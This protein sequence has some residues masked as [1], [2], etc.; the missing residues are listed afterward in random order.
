MSPL[1]NYDAAYGGKKGAG[2]KA[3][4]AMVAQYGEKRG[5]RMFYA[6]ANM[7]KKAYGKAARKMREVALAQPSPAPEITEAAA[8]LEMLYVNGFSAVQDG[9]LSFEAV[10]SAV[11]SAVSEYAKGEDG[12]MARMPCTVVA[13]FL[14]T[15]V[16]EHEGKLYQIDYK[17]NGTEATLD[18]EAAEVAAD[19]VP[20]G[21]ALGESRQAPLIEARPAGTIRHDQLNRALNVIEGTVLITSQSVNGSGK[22][23]RR[24]SDNALRQIAER[25]EGLPAY[26]NHVA[27]EHA[28][29]P[30]DVRDLIGSHRNI[31]YYPNEG[32]IVS[33]LHIAEHQAPLVFGLATTLG[34]HIGNSLV[35]RGL[36]QMEGD[37]EVVKEIADVRSVDLVS[38]PATTKGLFEARADDADPLG[39]L[40]T[41]LRESLTHVPKEDPMDLAAILTFLKDK[42]EQQALVAESFGFVAKPAAGKLQEQ[43]VTLTTERDTFKAK[44]DE[45]EAAQVKTTADLKEATIKLD[46]YKAKDAL[47]EKR[48]KI[49][50]AI[51]AH[52]LGKQFGKIKEVVSDGFKTML[53]GLDEAQWKSVLDDRFASLKAVPSSGGTP[54]SERKSD[55]LLT[56]HKDGDALP[57]GLEA[58]LAAAL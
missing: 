28:F 47:A 7:K 25:A 24:Y 45:V 39:T 3:H 22:G 27:A 50:T 34:G 40:I 56:E 44:A 18:G 12:T 29:K 54:R 9:D 2:R 15:C 37:T 5:N 6:K 10:T 19:F 1:S 20:V 13:T 26:L 41:E 46:G 8:L 42:P 38:D 21:R 36:V 14:G 11:Q 49:V 51:E 53:E 32:K 4:A 17:L 52:D 30:R 48:A 35:S 16:Y 58:R 57:A 31:R 43:I 55:D 23:G 33:D